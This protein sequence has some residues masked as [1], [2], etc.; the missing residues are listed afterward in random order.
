VA[1]LRFPYVFSQAEKDWVAM[2]RFFSRFWPFSA[3]LNGNAPF[4]NR[5]LG[6]FLDLG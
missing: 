3:F 6:P 5:I 1:M 2:L 4:F